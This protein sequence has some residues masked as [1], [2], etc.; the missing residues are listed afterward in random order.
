MFW[1]EVRYLNEVLAAI[2]TFDMVGRLRVRGWPVVACYEGSVGEVVS[3]EV[4]S[5]LTLV[6]F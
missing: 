5:A 4:V 6:K 3:T 2:T 1:R